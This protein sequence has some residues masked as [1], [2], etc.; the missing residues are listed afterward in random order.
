VTRA[1]E[2]AFAQPLPVASGTLLELPHRM[3]PWQQAPAADEAPPA[4]A[5]FAAGGVLVGDGARALVPLAAIDASTRRAWVRNGLGQVVGADVD[6]GDA[7]L[8]A[9]GL[10][11][12]KLHAALPLGASAE[13]SVRDPFAGSPGYALQFAATPAPAWPWLAQGFL[14]PAR[15]DGTRALGFEPAGA[16]PGAAVLDSTGRLA[17]IT[18]GARGGGVAWVPASR[19][20][21][22]LGAGTVPAPTGAEAAPRGLVSPDAIYE[23]GMRRAVQV[24]VD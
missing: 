11:L 19:W 16:T 7:T 14:G 22:A 1:A 18:L 3:A 12:L 4:D 8:A 13:D 20:Q 23:L 5:R 10:A 2:A 15:A 6:R 21:A 9:A 24:L 17:G